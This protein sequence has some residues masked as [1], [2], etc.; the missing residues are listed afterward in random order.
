MQQAGIKRRPLFLR[1]MD[2]YTAD[3][4]RA[5]CRRSSRLSQTTAAVYKKFA[6]R[7]RLAAQLARAVTAP[8]QCAAAHAR[9]AD[10]PLKNVDWLAVAAKTS[11]W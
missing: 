11:L 2:G 6:G 3:L 5:M 9:H 10:N 7:E 4:T 8:W 1:G